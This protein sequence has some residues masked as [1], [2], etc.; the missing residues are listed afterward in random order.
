[1]LKKV[2]R[3]EVLKMIQ[4]LDK[5]TESLTDDD[6]N[7]IIDM[8][9]AELNTIA[10]PFENEEVVPLK[11]YYD[12]GELK[13][14][15]DVVED[16]SYVYDLYLTI[17]GHQDIH[18]YKHGVQ[19]LR[20]ENVVYKDGRRVGRVHV[21]LTNLKTLAEADNK[22]ADN[23][24]IKYSYTPTH[25]T[26]DIYVDQ[27]T[28]LAMRDAFGCA[29]YNRLND[30]DRESQKRAALGRTASAIVP[31]YPNDFRVPMDEPIA[32]EG[33]SYVRSMFNGLKV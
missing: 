5:R 7:Y 6:F 24:V 26:E 1:M 15:V 16:V 33:R 4:T 2:T 19:K 32:E 9:Y 31:R 10:H 17:E 14:T 18:Q 23:L 25:T 27:P 13:F 30:T 8:G 29:L 21:D 3:A 28:L 12:N 11:P 22:P 20:N